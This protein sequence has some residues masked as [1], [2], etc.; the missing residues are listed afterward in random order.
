MT[1]DEELA[2][3]RVTFPNFPEEVFTLW[4]DD[5]IR[6]N[7]WPPAGIEW[8][9]FFEGQ[10]IAYWQSLQWR[11]ERLTLTFEELTPTTFMIVMQLVEAAIGKSNMMSRYIPNTAERFMSCLGYVQSNETT[12]GVVILHRSDLG[13]FVIDGNHRIAALLAFQAGASLGTP[14]LPV[15]AWVAGKVS[16]P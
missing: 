3:A 15:E 16:D 4:L 12:P 11:R 1:L 14:P 8:S 2:D 10:P 9:G 13:I 5:R 6:Q 7:G